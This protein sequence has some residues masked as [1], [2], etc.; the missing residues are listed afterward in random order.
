MCPINRWCGSLA[1]ASRSNDPIYALSNELKLDYYR[2][3]KI[4]DLNFSIT[5]FDNL[6]Q[7]FLTIFQCITLE[8]WIDVTNMFEDS[9]TVWFVEVYFLLCIIVCSFF[10]LNLTI[11]VMLLKYEEY[12]KENQ[13]CSE[14]MQELHE[15]GEKIGLPLRFTEFLIDQDNIQISLKGLKVL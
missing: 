12:D 11:A 1:E 4:E 5:N 9:Y 10:V 2:D 13:D 3:A 14:H 7:A 8:G 6:P 15:Y